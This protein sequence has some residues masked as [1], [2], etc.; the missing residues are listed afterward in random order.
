MDVKALQK[1]FSGEILANKLRVNTDK[2]ILIMARLVKN[3]WEMT[4][5]GEKHCM[6]VNEAEAIDA[7][8]DAPTPEVGLEVEPPK[9]KS[10]K[11]K[12]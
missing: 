1:R 6:A 11:A 12:K 9:S 3:E 7:D 8:A 10:S 4:P 2:G 5:E